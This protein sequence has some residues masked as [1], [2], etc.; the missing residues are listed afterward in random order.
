MSVRF[1]D[2]ELQNPALGNA[3]LVQKSQQVLR[4]PG[5]GQAFVYDLDVTLR[6]IELPFRGLRSAEKAALEAFF[7][8]TVEGAHEEFLFRDHHDA[9]HLAH[10]AGVDLAFRCADDEPAS[11]GTFSSG[12]STY[13][14]TAREKAVWDVD[15]ELEAVPLDLLF[16]GTM[17]DASHQWDSIFTGSGGL[18]D[19]HADAAHDG[20]LGS[21]HY[22]PGASG[23]TSYGKK[24]VAAMQ[25][26][27]VEFWLNIADL[28][29]ADG[30]GFWIYYDGTYYMH[31][32]R[33]GSTYRVG[34]SAGMAA[35]DKSGWVRVENFVRQESRAGAQDGQRIILVGG[36]VAYDVGTSGYLYV[37]G[38]KIHAGA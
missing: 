36:E 3:Q 4:P 32:E 34:V 35:I 18:H 33:S 9:L 30:D 16:D 31:V 14:T 11:S 20:A 17:E 1:N 29:M 12:G 22:L 21:R 25:S 5:S 27:C 2:V 10:F 13:P 8:T 23:G 15:I 6:R 7:A 28:T 37:D 26:Y 24:A 38:V 19:Y